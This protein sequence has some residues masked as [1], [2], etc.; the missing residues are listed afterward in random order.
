MGTVVF[1]AIPEHVSDN[2]NRAGS[3]GESDGREKKQVF[4]LATTLLKLI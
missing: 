2:K 4:I 1:K 3:Q